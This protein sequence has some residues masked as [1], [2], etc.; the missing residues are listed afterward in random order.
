MSAPG[1]YRTPEFDAFHSLQTEIER[2][3]DRL[4]KLEAATT[5]TVPVYSKS[6][7]GTRDLILGQV[8]V[9]KDNT[10]NYLSG[11]V[12]SVSVYEIHGTLYT[13]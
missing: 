2:L 4:R 11:T 6:S 9:G 1:R 12:D 10:L 13:F 5:A 3:K 8:F 7:L